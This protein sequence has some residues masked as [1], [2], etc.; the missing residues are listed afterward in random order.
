[1]AGGTG[2][3]NETNITHTT[4]INLDNAVIKANKDASGTNAIVVDAY[5]NVKS[6]DYQ[7]IGTGAVIEA[8][9]INDDNNN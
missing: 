6:K 3:V 2:I 4:D 9:E 1:M 5:S 7:Y 8:A